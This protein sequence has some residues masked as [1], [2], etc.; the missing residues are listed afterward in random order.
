MNSLSFLDHV[1]QDVDE[2][3][4]KIEKSKKIIC[5]YGEKINELEDYKYLLFKAREVFHT[6]TSVEVK[7]YDFDKMSLEQLQLVNVSGIIHSKDLHKF[8][9]MIFRIT[10]GN[11]I[12]YTFNIPKEF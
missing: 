9:K 5:E 1:E 2:N 8:T 7:D 4:E 11:S 3:F 12:L 6:T 10:K